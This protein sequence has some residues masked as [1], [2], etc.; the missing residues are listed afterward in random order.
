MPLEHVYFLTSAIN[1]YT[2]ASMIHEIILRWKSVSYKCI[3][4]RPGSRKK[5]DEKGNITRASEWTQT[6]NQVTSVR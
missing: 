1:A 2:N 4:Y 6:S 5:I 3:L